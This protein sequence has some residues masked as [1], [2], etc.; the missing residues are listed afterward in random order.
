MLAAGVAHEVN[1]P[2]SFVTANVMFLS[3]GLDLCARALRGEPLTDSEREDL[4]FLLNEG[5]QVVEETA[6]GCARIGQVVRRLAAFTKEGDDQPLD[7]AR[8]VGDVTRA[9]QSGAGR[10]LDLVVELTQVP[11]LQGNPV[12]LAHAIFALVEHA[13]EAAARGRTGVPRVGVR[14]APADLG[15]AAVVEICDS[16]PPLTPEQLAAF[17]DPFRTT[18]PERTAFLGLAVACDIVREH[19]GAVVLAETADGRNVRRVILPASAS[20]A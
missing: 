1:N 11:Q 18:G 13:C 12:R 10:R 20:A 16:G 2:L 6:D 7:L 5:Q 8:I 17:E 4:E 9:V 19:G 15:A 3:Q 14:V